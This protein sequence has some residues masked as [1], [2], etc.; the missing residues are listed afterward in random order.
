[1][2][3]S[4][5][6]SLDKRRAKKD[7]TYPIILRLSH[8][9]RTINIATG[10]SIFEKYWDEQNR[11]VKTACNT[12]DNVSRANNYLFKKRS[13]AMDLIA[14]LDTKKKLQ[15]LSAVQIKEKLKGR[16]TKA[17]FFTYTQQLID[18]FDET[19]R[20]G[21]ARSYRNV[22]REVKNFK[23]DVDFRIEEI[24][25]E[26]LMN[27]EKAYLSRGN[28]VNGLAVYTR[29]IRAIFNYAIKDHLVEKSS[30]PFD[31]YIIKTK[32]TTKRA[33][34]FESIKKIVELE[35]TNENL[36]LSRNIFL[37]SFY[38]MGTSF[39]DIAFW[40][41]EY[42]A[43]GRIKYTRQKTGRPYNIKITP[44][45]QEI[46]N[47][48]LKK[49]TRTGFIFPILKS[50]DPK[51]RHKQEVDALIDHNKRL[52]KIAKLA[53]IEETLTSYV[54][55]H[56]FATL[57]NNKGVPVTAISTMLGH[58]DLR[59]TQGYLASLNNNIIDDYNDQII[60]GM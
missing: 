59:T 19:E 49:K 28:S 30:Y 20:F 10:Y 53:G 1:M 52:K 27:F 54:S 18:R 23:N 41:K 45:L 40:R 26:F 50:Q 46:L 7:G 29:T 12:I 25:Y 8:G 11:K 42:I 22:L 24:N 14:E 3:T 15:T 58:G 36:I 60:N 51:Q 9:R 33:I 16:S 4:I 47:Y 5:T 57:A 35:L 34:P 13:E 38:A 55:R 32:P 43:E 17:T 2:N 6:L 31:D 48:Y 37:T 21:N 56:S 44:Q 39:S